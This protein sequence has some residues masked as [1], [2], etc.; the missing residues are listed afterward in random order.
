MDKQAKFY[1]V[2]KLERSTVILAIFA[3]PRSPNL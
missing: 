2:E 1:L 3:G